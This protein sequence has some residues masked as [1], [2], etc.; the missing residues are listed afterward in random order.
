MSEYLQHHGILGQKWGKRNGPPYPLGYSDHS[1]AEKS[2]LS[3][4]ERFRS[5]RRVQ[6]SGGTIYKKGYKFDRVGLKDLDFNESGGL[7]VSQNERDSARYIKSLSATPLT[8]FFKIAMGDHIQHLSLTDDAK[9]ASEEVTEKEIVKC[10]I[11]NRKVLDAFNNS[12]YS[13]DLVLGNASA[14]FTKEY[15]SKIVDSPSDQRFRVAFYLNTMLGDSYNYGETNKIVLNHFKDLGYD[16]IPDLHDI[17]SGTSEEPL[18][19]INSSK[20]KLDEST[21]INRQDYKEAKAL[22]KKYEKLKVDK[23]V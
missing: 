11:Q 21:A 1:T 20:V 9:V 23:R 15:L 13:Y 2:H 3:D 5:N 4:N 16:A 22:V 12:F 14:D 19:I 10:L 6:T 17:H 18:I 8:K 7:Y